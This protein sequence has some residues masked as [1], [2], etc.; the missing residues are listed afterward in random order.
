VADLPWVRKRWS[1]SEPAVWAAF[2]TD[3]PLAAELTANPPE[4]EELSDDG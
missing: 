4:H 3:D 2:H 1:S